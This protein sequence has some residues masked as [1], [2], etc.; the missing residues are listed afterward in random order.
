MPIKRFQFLNHAEFCRAEFRTYTAPYL[1]KLH[2]A[3]RQH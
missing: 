3:D 1:Q 2:V